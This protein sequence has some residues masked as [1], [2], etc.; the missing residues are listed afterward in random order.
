[1]KSTAMGITPLIETAKDH[2]LRGDSH[3]GVPAASGKMETVYQTLK[4]HLPSAVVVWVTEIPFEKR[5][6]L[7]QPLVHTVVHPLYINAKPYLY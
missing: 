4:S 6:L 3:G 2:T 5:I 7:P 1:M